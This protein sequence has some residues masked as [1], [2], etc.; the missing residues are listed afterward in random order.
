[1]LFSNE[2]QKIKD[3]NLC[4]ESLYVSLLVE[5]ERFTEG[6]RMAEA[7]LRKLDFENSDKIWKY[8]KINRIRC[9]FGLDEHEKV[10]EFVEEFLEE[11]STIS[12]KDKL[13]M[14]SILMSCLKKTHQLEKAEQIMV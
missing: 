13:K 8:A 12:L 9:L 11:Y 6:F 7:L 10:I 3:Y 4:L 2:K 1:M 5:E 14:V